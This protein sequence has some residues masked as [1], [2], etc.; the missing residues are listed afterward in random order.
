MLSLRLL[1]SYDLSCLCCS[2][3]LHA[4]FYIYLSCLAL[5]NIATLGVT[6]EEPDAI[7]SEIK[8][9][10]EETPQQFAEWTPNDVFLTLVY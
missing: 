6:G 7:A 4:I 5:P 2:F 9:D 3:D 10:E 1:S 8:E